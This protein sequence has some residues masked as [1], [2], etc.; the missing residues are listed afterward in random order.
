MVIFQD[1]I[2]LG[3]S[4]DFC[5]NVGS[6]GFVKAH[7]FG[8]IGR[9][10]LQR[11]AATVEVGIRHEGGDCSSVHSLGLV[12]KDEDSFLEDLDAGGGIGEL[13]LEGCEF[14]VLV[15]EFSFE[16]TGLDF[17]ELLLVGDGVLGGG[18]VIVLEESDG[19]GV[20]GPL[21]ELLGGLDGHG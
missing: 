2:L 15:G 17:I 13:G 4:L 8:V 18:G 5:I 12:F 6:L 11:R 10:V 7:E 16:T 21:V 14:L 20:V 1:S 19:T 9:T 3:Q